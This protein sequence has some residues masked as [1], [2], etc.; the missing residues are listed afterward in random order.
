LHAAADQIMSRVSGEAL[1]SPKQPSERRES[2]EGFNWMDLAI[3]LFFAVPIAGA[4]LRA[5]L[6]RKLG[7]LVTGAGVGTIALFITSSII[8]AVI[9]ALVALLFSMFSGALPSM[10]GPRRG[11]WGGGPWI[12]GG[13]RGGGWASGGGAGGGWSSGGGGDFGGGGAS[14]DW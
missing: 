14:G 4:A 11:G 9:A 6:G 10:G 1:P 2:G 7:A 12:G 5:V 3:F 8:V 13:G